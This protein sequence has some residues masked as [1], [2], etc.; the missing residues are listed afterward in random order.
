MV[1]EVTVS[2]TTVI[3][4]GAFMA[5]LIG[6]GWTVFQTQ[7]S[8]QAAQI[9]ENKQLIEQSVRLLQAQIDRR[10]G[11]LERRD[12][13]LTAKALTQAEFKQFE[14]NVLAQIE[15]LR[16]QIAILEQTRPTTGELQ[17]ANRSSQDTAARLE[18]RVRSLEQYLLG[19]SKGFSTPPR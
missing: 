1:R 4:A 8:S 9:N 6:G 16:R 13:A 10:V 14:A 2:W 12:D 7:F 5:V 18:E 15:G 19:Q 3:S 11:E 17:A